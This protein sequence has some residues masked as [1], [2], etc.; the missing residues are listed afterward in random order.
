MAEIPHRLQT[1]TDFEQSK[2]IINE[3]FAAIDGENRTK[4]IKNGSTPTV[5][6]G[7]QKDGFG[8]GVDYGFKVAKSGFNVT[9]ADDEDLAFSSA[10]NSLKIVE[11]GTAFVTR[12]A[13]TTTGSTTVTYDL[14]Y[15][16][17]VLA[18]HDAGT[19]PSVTVGT[20]TGL[21]TDMI[22]MSH[23]AFANEITFSIIAPD[24]V[25]N[26]VRTFGQNANIRY[27]LLRETLD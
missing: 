15:T 23:N 7:Y 2:P 12:A 9:T 25:G 4:I 24:Y 26:S 11:S 16:P 5:L 10:F 20:T 1:G 13:N 8:T 19:I 14:D 21:V 18:F 22:Q 27:Y 17:I 3:A 6:M